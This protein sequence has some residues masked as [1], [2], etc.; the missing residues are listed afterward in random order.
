VLF[1]SVVAEVEPKGSRRELVERREV[2][3]Q[4][5]CELVG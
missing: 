3:E 1:R 2:A 5:L 4:L